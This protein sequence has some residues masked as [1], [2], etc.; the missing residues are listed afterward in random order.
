ML[1]FQID[2]KTIETLFNEKKTKTIHKKVHQ[3]CS[4]SVETGKALI[5]QGNLSLIKSIY[6]SS[7]SKSAEKQSISG[8]CGLRVPPEQRGSASEL[9][10][11][12]THDPVISL[13]ESIEKLQ[14]T[15]KC[16][17]YMEIHLKLLLRKTNVKAKHCQQ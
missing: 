11:M 8:W 3:K 1:I 6:L 16:Y 14:N 12:S 9:C 13:W 17:K 10:K 2:K 15:G 7:A 4:A 5:K